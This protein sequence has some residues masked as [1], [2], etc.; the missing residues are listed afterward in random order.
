SRNALYSSG[1]SNPNLASKLSTTDLES[2]SP[3]FL[4]CKFS[5]TIIFNIHHHCVVYIG[6]L[7]PSAALPP[8]APVDPPAAMYH[9]PFVDYSPP[10]DAKWYYLVELLIQQ[11]D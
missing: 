9:F 4:K 8:Y 5:I 10:H 3:I 1:N 11:L 7:R 2:P 6:Q